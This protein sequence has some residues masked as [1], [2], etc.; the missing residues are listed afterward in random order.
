MDLR[1][2]KGMLVAILIFWFVL[3]FT[4]IFEALGKFKITNGDAAIIIAAI[5]SLVEDA[6]LAHM[7]TL[8][9]E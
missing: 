4:V 8:S 7:L 1:E 3:C 5:V 6:V 2:R 9:H